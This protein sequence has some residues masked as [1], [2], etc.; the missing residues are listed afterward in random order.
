MVFESTLRVHMFSHESVDL[1]NFDIVPSRLPPRLYTLMY[2]V[3]RDIFGRA[4][5]TTFNMQRICDVLAPM[6]ATC[7]GFLSCSRLVPG[8]LTVDDLARYHAIARIVY[9]RSSDQQQL[10]AHEARKAG[11]DLSHAIA[12]NVAGQMQIGL[13]WFSHNQ[14]TP[15]RTYS[16]SDLERLTLSMPCDELPSCLAKLNYL[17]P[18][19]AI[20]IALHAGVIERDGDRYYLNMNALRL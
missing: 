18:R 11:V 9:R 2:N 12:L 15:L 13:R 16:D 6:F 8:V 4:A 5:I 10:M 1:P 7:I 19:R 3:H 14:F 17:E 20:N